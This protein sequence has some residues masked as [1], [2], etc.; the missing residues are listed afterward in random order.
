MQKPET[1]E[2]ENVPPALLLAPY[3]ASPESIK[4][5]IQVG[6]GSRA[7]FIVLEGTSLSFS[8]H[9][10]W[11]RR[12]WRRV[13]VFVNGLAHRVSS[14]ESI[15]LSIQVCAVRA[16]KVYPLL[17]LSAWVGIWGGRYGW[18]QAQVLMSVKE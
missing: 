6:A 5:S 12:W 17:L 18:Q 16:A 3:V 13:W 4:L 1:V 10:G 9:A 2:L 15:K 14:P 8:L 7:S 11:C